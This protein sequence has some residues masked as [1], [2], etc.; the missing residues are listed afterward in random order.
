MTWFL[1][2]FLVLSDLYELIKLTFFFFRFSEV[3]C[4]LLPP[5][6]QCYFFFSK[7]IPTPPPSTP[8]PPPLS[9]TSPDL[10][11]SYSPSALWSLMPSTK[12]KC[13]FCVFPQN[14]A[15]LLSWHLLLCRDLSG[16]LA[17]KSLRQTEI[18]PSVCWVAVEWTNAKFH[19]KQHCPRCLTLHLFS[20]VENYR[21]ISIIHA[22]AF[23][24]EIITDWQESCK[25][26]TELLIS[27]IHVHVMLTFYITIMQWSKLRN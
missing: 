11:N 26:S 7:H 13:C 4:F 10:A 21:E 23:F 22:I 6:L 5:F 14:H 8:P 20:S 18:Q 25:N 17:A 12:V 3:T 1:L 24:L 19:C 27:F 15:L 16:L 2:T 9:P